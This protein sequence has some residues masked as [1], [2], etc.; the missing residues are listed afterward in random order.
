MSTIQFFN[1]FAPVY[2]LTASAQGAPAYD[3]KVV[4]S[5]IYRNGFEYYKMG[6]AGAESVVLLVLVMS[7]VTLQ[8][9]LF[10]ERK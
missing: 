10:R 5:E 7:M 3:L 9:T 6:Y 8:F 2:V 1:V 4:V